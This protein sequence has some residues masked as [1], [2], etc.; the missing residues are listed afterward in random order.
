MKSTLLKLSFL[1]ILV[2]AMT[3]CTTNIKS[4]AKSEHEQNSKEYTSKY[5]CPM[6]CEGS[7]S[8]TAGICPVCSMD[9]VKNT[10]K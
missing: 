1:L 7:G 10:T 4:D 8:D 5:I 3:A 2:G 9:Y 6:H